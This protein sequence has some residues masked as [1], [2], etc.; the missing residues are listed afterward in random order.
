MNREYVSRIVDAE[1]DE[2]LAGLPAIA[3]EG[4]K[5]VGKTATALRRARTVHR[6]DDQAERAI[7][8]AAPER[9]VVGDGPILLD[10]W[11]R[12]P[13]SWELVRRA[14]DDGAEPG[15]FLLT[16]SASNTDTRTHSGAGRIVTLRMRPLSLPERGVAEPTVSLRRLLS[17]LGDPVEG[18]TGLKLADYANEIVASGFPGLRNLPGRPLRAQLDGY[19]H[20]IVDRDFAELGKVVRRPAMLHAWLAAYAAATATTASYETIRDAASGGHAEKPS[21]STTIPYRDTLQQLWIV[22]PLPA[23]VPHHNQIAR[24]SSPVKH[25]L[26]DPA[27]AARLCGSDETALLGD[28]RLIG[29]LFESLVTLNVRV[30][31]Q[32]LE[33]NVAHLRTWRGEHEIDLIVERGDGK[34]V[35]IE[36]KLG[37]EPSDGELKHLK[38]LREQLGENLLDAVVVTTGQEAYRR[39]DGI[40]VVPAALLG[41]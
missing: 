37:K 41:P 12:V 35:A 10:E 1:L 24:M 39:R 23:W 28:A 14:V 9:L 5:A 27:L 6:L 38:W 20:R 11:Q 34:V 32:A 8:E 15:R 22:D 40:A 31:A 4:T 19:I 16:G 2:L 29:A 30:F 13:D 18:R 3:L 36:V 21:K 7:L 17:G 33:A 25:H 26:A